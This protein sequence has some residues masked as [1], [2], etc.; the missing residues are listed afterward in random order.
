MSRFTILAPRGLLRDEAMR[1]LEPIPRSIDLWFRELKPDEIQRY[2]ADIDSDPIFKIYDIGIQH[3][4][5]ATREEI[6][7]LVSRLQTKWPY[8]RAESEPPLWFTP[9]TRDSANLQPPT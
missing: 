3:D 1:C 6:D 7:L 4:A 5:T 9:T 8:V 2:P